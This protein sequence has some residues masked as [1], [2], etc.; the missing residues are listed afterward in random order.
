[1]QVTNMS[2]ENTKLKVVHIGEKSNDNSHYTVQQVVEELLEDLKKED[3]DKW[4]GVFIALV[5]KQQGI[6]NTGYRIANL[7]ASESI[8]LLE[9]M[10]TRMLGSMN[11]V[12]S[13]DNT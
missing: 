8:S 12:K 1:M 11:F 5:D 6:Y 4:T 13:S 9:I 2:T 10:K 7:S 3:A